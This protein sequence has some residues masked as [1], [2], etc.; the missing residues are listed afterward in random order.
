[1]GR[2]RDW[3]SVIK[4]RNK[5]QSGDKYVMQY[6]IKLGEGIEKKA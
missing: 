1:V 3:L 5:L 4:M 2:C 6:V